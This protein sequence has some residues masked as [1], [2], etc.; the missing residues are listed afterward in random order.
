[1]EI[2]YNNKVPILF[3]FHSCHKETPRKP[4]K[5]NSTSNYINRHTFTPNT[6]NFTNAN[7][8]SMINTT[9]TAP[10]NDSEVQC[11]LP[12]ITPFKHALA[13]EDILTPGTFTSHINKEG[14]VYESTPTVD[15]RGRG[16]KRK[17]STG[18]EPIQK[19]GN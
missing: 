3:Y 10:R 1:M 5:S 14:G 12:K 9:I 16:V 19:N 8:N 18:N 13:N 2:K 17:L 6:S 7:N 11:E 15:I 4:S